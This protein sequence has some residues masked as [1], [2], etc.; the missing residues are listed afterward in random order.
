MSNSVSCIGI[1]I[2]VLKDLDLVFVIDL[3]LVFVIILDS[4]FGQS[5]SS[6]LLT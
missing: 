2:L 4:D 1:Q 3:D 5:S 6:Q